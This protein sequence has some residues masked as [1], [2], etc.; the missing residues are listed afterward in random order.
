[1]TAERV[2]RRLTAV[3]RLTGRAAP[4]EADGASFLGCPYRAAETPRRTGGSHGD[5]MAASYT[6][7]MKR[8]VSLWIAVAAILLISIGGTAAQPKSGGPAAEPKRIVV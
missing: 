8:L 1:M 7:Q 3:W 6:L 5:R 4:M 2:E